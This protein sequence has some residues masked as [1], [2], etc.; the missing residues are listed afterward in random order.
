MGDLPATNR[1]AIAI[2]EF[3]GDVST[4]YFG[5]KET[6]SIFNPIVKIVVRTASYATGKEW[7]EQIK[8][9]LHR[10][11]DDTFL[12]IMIV[13]DILDLGRDPQKLHEFQLTF[14]TQVRSDLD[15]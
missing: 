12:S 15:G 7:A 8:E 5:T 10:Y 13:G 11:H 1:E 14:K 2:M 6:S 9:L 3:D 4:E